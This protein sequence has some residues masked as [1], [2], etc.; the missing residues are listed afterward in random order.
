MP[1]QSAIFI[2][3]AYLFNVLRNELEGA[4][5]NFEL[6]PSKLTQGTNLIRTYYY[7]S[8]PYR[9]DPPTTQE[10]SFYNRQRQFF[11]LAE[12]APEIHCQIGKGGA[13]RE[14]SRRLS[15]N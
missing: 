10:N 15:S 13:P 12:T 5:I 3:G 2:D 1:E 7:S 8:L 14:Q 4:R 11:S 6:L 9:S